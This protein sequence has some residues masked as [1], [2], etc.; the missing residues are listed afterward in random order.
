MLRQFVAA[1]PVLS[2]PVPSC[3]VSLISESSSC[4]FWPLL[5]SCAF[6]I[7]H[8]PVTSLLRLLVIKDW[9]LFF[10]AIARLTTKSNSQ[11]T[12]FLTKLAFQTGQRV[13][14]QMRMYSDDFPI[15]LLPLSSLSPPPAN[16][17]EKSKHC[18]FLVHCGPV[19]IFTA[20]R[21][22]LSHDR[23]SAGL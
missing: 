2:R 19:F 14:S 23:A 7:A 15:S 18:F 13:I 4:T 12:F 9:L 8:K 22:L 20:L 6:D 3:P 10:S 11:A 21:M 1:I 5:F 17:F 16:P